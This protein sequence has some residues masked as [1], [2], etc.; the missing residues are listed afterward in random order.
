MTHEIRTYRNASDY[1]D[2]VGP[3]LLEDEPFHSLA[4]G[5]AARFTETDWRPDADDSAPGSLL[6]SA[7]HPDGSF[8]FAAWC[9][10]PH[11]LTVTGGDAGGL[12]ALVDLIHARGGELTRCNGPMESIEPLIECVGRPFTV[13]META[14]HRLDAVRL[15]ERPAQ[16]EIA[17]ATMEDRELI[18]HWGH[19]FAV[20]SGLAPK[21]SEPPA[22]PVDLDAAQ[23]F[24]AKNPD[25]KIVSMTAI[26]RKTPRS[27]NISH[28]Y[29]PPEERGRGYASALVADVSQRVLD[30][31]KDYCT[32]YTDLANPTSNKIYQALGYRRIGDFRVIE[33]GD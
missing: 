17:A 6:A 33:F 30:S 9:T 16:I 20:D 2:D 22:E 32:L 11:A 15:P 28:V 19:W 3:F 31:G 12:R 26:T 21:G 14:L 29:T 4:I 27:G 5:L 8:D 18:R 7:W 23:Y 24:L 1:W 13:G 25:G 10:P